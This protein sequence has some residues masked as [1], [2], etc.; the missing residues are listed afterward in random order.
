M[1][2]HMG[3]AVFQSNFTKN[4]KRLQTTGLLTT[5]DSVPLQKMFEQ[6]IYLCL[7][8]KHICNT[9]L[10]YVCGIK[11]GGLK[12]VSRT[13]SYFLP[14]PQRTVLYTPLRVTTLVSLTFAG[15]VY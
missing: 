15:A 8:M 3:A 7:F 9:V 6:L 4:A 13:S 11:G 14:M 1:H 2:K 5:T 12:Y 10:T